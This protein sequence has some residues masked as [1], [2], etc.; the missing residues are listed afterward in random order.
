MDKRKKK[1]LN[2]EREKETRRRKTSREEGQMAGI[3]E[4]NPRNRE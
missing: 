4:V 1:K 2:Q 3:R